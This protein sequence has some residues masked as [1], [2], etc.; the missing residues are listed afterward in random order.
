MRIIAGKF[1]GKVL[2]KFDLDTTRPTSDLI[3]EALFDKIGVDVDCST[4][5]DLFSGTGAVGIEALSR[6]AKFCYFVDSEKSAINII[7]KNLSKISADNFEVINNK[8]DVALKGFAKQNL[9]FDF[10]FLDPPYKSD[11]AERAIDMLIELGLV[12]E[13]SLIVWEHDS[14]K[15]NYV[16]NSFKDFKTK[17]YGQKFLTYIYTTK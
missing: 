3:R 2:T 8:F 9:T 1:K 11:F 4:F 13:N 14:S 5:L 15:L 16:E 17:K 7:K 12:N 6:N 10:V